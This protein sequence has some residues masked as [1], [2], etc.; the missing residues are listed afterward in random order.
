MWLFP[1]HSCAEGG[2]GIHRHVTNEESTLG[3]RRA[4]A[5]A[6]ECSLKHTN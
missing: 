1:T 4:P 3:W 6:G 2:G 5:A